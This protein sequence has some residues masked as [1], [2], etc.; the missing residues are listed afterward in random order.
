VECGFAVGNGVKRCLMHCT[1]QLGAKRGFRHWLQLVCWASHTHV[2][3][4]MMCSGDSKDN[5]KCWKLS[6][7]LELICN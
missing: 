6:G 7:S 4:F 5:W 3:V 2:Q 1:T